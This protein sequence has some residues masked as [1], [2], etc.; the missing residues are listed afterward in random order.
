M[1][2]F[3]ISAK[4]RKSRKNNKQNNAGPTKSTQ[5][6]VTGAFDRIGFGSFSQIAPPSVGSVRSQKTPQG[7]TAKPACFVVSALAPS[8]LAELHPLRAINEKLYL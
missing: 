7:C 4:I 6:Q 2:D 3:E 8:K 5:H 1:A